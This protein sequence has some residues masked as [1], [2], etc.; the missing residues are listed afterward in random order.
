MLPLKLRPEHYMFLLTHRHTPVGPLVPTE[1]VSSF[2]RAQSTVR[3]LIDS[4][5]RQEVAA[6]MPIKRLP[7]AYPLD[8]C[9]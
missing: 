7:S 4:G 8:Q 9:R 1:H 5:D 6:A 2:E 3:E